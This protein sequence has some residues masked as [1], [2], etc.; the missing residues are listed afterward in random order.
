MPRMAEF[1][2]SANSAGRAKK[3]PAKRGKSTDQ[4]VVAAAA[5]G[6]PVSP[7]LTRMATT[8]AAWLFSNSRARWARAP[9]P[10]I[11]LGIFAGVA[12]FDR[13]AVSTVEATTDPATGK[14]RSD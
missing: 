9:L 6:V 13:G 11:A 14:L 5:G 4:V 7:C 1:R 10:L 3:S 12:R 2:P 8:A